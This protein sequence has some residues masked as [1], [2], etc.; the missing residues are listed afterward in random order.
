MVGLAEPRI[1]ILSRTFQQAGARGVVGVVT[2][3]LKATWR[4]GEIWQLGRFVGMPTDIV[5]LDGCKFTIDQTCVPSNIIELLLSNRY[6]E[7]ER[8]ALKDFLDP[9]LPVVELGGC[10]GVVS[11]LTNRLLRRPEAHVVVEANPGLLPILRHHRERN[12]CRFQVVHAALS[13]EAETIAF[14]VNDNVLA[15][16][17]YGE[18]Q[19]AVIVP[20]VTLRHLLNRYGFEQ[21]TLIC[22]IEGAELGLVEHEIATLVG[23]VA[24]IIMELHGRFDGDEPAAGM[25]AV[26]ERAGFAL[27]RKDH[28]VVVLLN[29]AIGR[30]HA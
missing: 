18:D 1:R 19:Q 3:K 9:D 5:R 27:V 22:D 23:R 26:L 13:Y 20:T 16:S 8:H 21:A 2:Q 4:R 29:E 25:L 14:N 10:I 12:E 30:R 15:S 6:E 17:V 24:A 11:C 28:D 7:P